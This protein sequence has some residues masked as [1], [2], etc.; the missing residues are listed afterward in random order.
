MNF[1]DGG[2]E[3]ELRERIWEKIVEKNGLISYVR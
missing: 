3:D 1:D 2:G